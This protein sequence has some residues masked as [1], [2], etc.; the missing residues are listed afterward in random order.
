MMC[1]NACLSCL[2]FFVDIWMVLYAEP[3]QVPIWGDY[4]VYRLEILFFL[5][6]L[7]LQ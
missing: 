3:F 5:I 1:L 2:A 7:Y 6:V 4:S